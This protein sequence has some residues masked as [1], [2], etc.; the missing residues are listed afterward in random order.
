MAI[1]HTKYQVKSKCKFCCRYGMGTI[2]KR[3]QR[4][5]RRTYGLIFLTP[6]TKITAKN[7]VLKPI[8]IDII[9]FFSHLE[10]YW[11]FQSSSERSQSQ[12]F[13]NKYL[14]MRTYTIH[15][16]ESMSRC[17]SYFTIEMYGKPCDLQTIGI[18]ELEGTLEVFQSNALFKQENLYHFRQV[19]SS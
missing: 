3:R 18:T 7:R 11:S 17:S 15:N 19:V 16:I 10:E 2:G 12:Y 6:V 4:E 13:S 5:E 1:F 14:F 8:Y 9:I